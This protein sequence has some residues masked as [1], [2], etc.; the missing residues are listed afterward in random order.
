MPGNEEVPR[1]W[2]RRGTRFEWRAG[3]RSDILADSAR[4]PGG[5]IMWARCPHARSHVMRCLKEVQAGLL[6]NV[7][8]RS[9]ESGGI[10]RRTSLRSWRGS[11]WGFES[12]LSHQTC[13]DREARAPFL[14]RI[15]GPVNTMDANANGWPA[16]PIKA[17]DEAKTER[18]REENNAEWRPK[19]SDPSGLLPKAPIAALQGLAGF[20]TRLR[21]RALRRAFSAVQR[22]CAHSV[23]RP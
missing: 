6:A 21:P 22:V 4:A 11:P 12:P 15:L 10:G 23:Y 18:L 1:A 19:P 8:R 14:T 20:P 13:A 9:R 17:A 16:A 5:G 7:P 2:R 3:T